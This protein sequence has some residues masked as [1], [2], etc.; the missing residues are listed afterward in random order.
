MVKNKKILVMGLT[1]SD[2]SNFCIRPFN[3]T[4][5]STD[6]S[7]SPC[8]RIKRK[9]F[10]IKTSTIAE[11][12]N[13]KYISQLRKKFLNNERPKECESCWNEENNKFE[14]H[15]LKSNFEYKAIF[16]N[17]YEKNLKLIKKN[18]LSYP[19]DIEFSITNICNLSCQMCS[20]KYSSKLLIENNH[21][22]LENLKQDNYNFNDKMD[23]EIQ[24]ILKHDL[25]LLNLRGGEPLV[26]KNIINLIEKLTVMNKAKNMTLH[27]TTNGTI[28]NNKILNLFNKFKKIT[29]ILQ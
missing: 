14:S 18:N 24:E 19:E 28:C 7:L 16:K 2:N 9:N 8:C 1:G 6:G 25:E 11:Y 29:N 15:R 23:K 17:N 13:N 12:W 22:N 21:L 27:I 3:S 4:V 20:G 5:I 26:N 10:N